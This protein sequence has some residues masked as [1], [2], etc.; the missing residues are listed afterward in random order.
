MGKT[1]VVS[2][3]RNTC[4]FSPRNFSGWVHLEV[5]WRLPRPGP[6]TGPFDRACPPRLSTGPAF[7]PL[8]PFDRAS[9]CGRAF[10]PPLSTGPRLPTG[11]RPSTAP[12]DRAFRL[13]PA[14]RL[15]RMGLSTRP[16]LSTG[17]FDRVSPSDRAFRPC[18]PCDRASPF[19]WAPPFDQAFRP[20]LS[21]G[22]CLSIGPALIAG[23]LD[24][25]LG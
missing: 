5:W 3:R 7:R 18:R 10:R 23:P 4:F 20:G 21:T 16:R 15:G 19:D 14:F 17:L 2:R 24:L 11:P 13:G 12:F 1:N 22:L 9:P 6:S 8:A 25:Y